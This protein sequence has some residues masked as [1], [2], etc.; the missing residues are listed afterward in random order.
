ME[1]FNRLYLHTIEFL[2][3]FLVINNNSETQDLVLELKN[4]QIEKSFWIS[5]KTSFEI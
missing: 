2:L 4:R 3:K 5:L 1:I